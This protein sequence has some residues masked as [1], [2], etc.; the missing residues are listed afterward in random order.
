MSSAV[1]HP[2]SIVRGTRRQR[3]AVAVIVALA[4]AVLI[5]CVGLALDLGKLYVT[6]S[7]LQNSADA[8]ALSAA[9][10]LTGTI[11]L[12]VAEADGLAAGTSNYVFFQNRQ[13]TNTSPTTLTVAFS[14]SL[15]NAFQSA[16]ALASPTNI[17]YVKCTTGL[18]SITNWFMQVLSVIPGVSVANASVTATAVATL[19]PG[20]TGCGIPVFICQQSGGTSYSVGQW[21]TMST[22]PSASASYG[23]GNFG[24]VILDPNASPSD[25]VL[26]NELTGNYCSLPPVNTLLGTTGFK[27]NDQDAWNTR[28][29]IYT[30]GG[31]GTPPTSATSNGLPDFTGYDYVYGGYQDMTKAG[32][33]YALGDAYT[34]FTQTDRPAF[35]PYQGTMSGGSAKSFYQS[36]GADRRVAV[37]PEADCSGLQ[38]SSTQVPVKK[39]D[40]VLLLQPMTGGKGSTVNI[41]YLGSSTDP[42]ATPCGT[43]GLPGN[44]TSTGAQVP[45]LI[46]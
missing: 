10:D 20:Q 12:W 15:S 29:G 21:F 37:A 36:Y 33:G 16:G 44:G 18:S 8:C 28:F 39:W 40:C 7:E 14:S 24:W 11:S 9:R 22:D 34:H 45:M 32:S 19:G 4:L 25:T 41:E 42:S 30:N 17:K 31:A 35:Q 13:I 6:R 23:P 26:R 46:Q 43:D 1:R 2:E 3:G 27:S 38:G 5:G